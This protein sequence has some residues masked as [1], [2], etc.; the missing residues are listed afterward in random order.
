MIWN[1]T[2]PS[3]LCLSQESIPHRLPQPASAFVVK[4]ERHGFLRQAQE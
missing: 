1:T 2:L 4:A 3:F